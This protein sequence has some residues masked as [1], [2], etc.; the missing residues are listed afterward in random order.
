M[1]EIFHFSPDRDISAAENLLNFINRCRDELT[2]FGRDVKWDD[3]K[4][5]GVANFTKLGAHSMGC[6]ETDKL[7]RG[8][9]EFSKAYLRYQQGHAPT[10]TKNELKALRLVEAAL[11]QHGGA[12]DLSL[13]TPAVLDVAA[14]LA[15]ENYSPGASYH[16]GRELERLAKFVTKKHLIANDLSSWVSP[17]RRPNDGDGINKTERDRRQEKLPSECAL[18]AL[19]E[20]F[21]GNPSN[22]RDI[23]TSS[24]F[25][26]SMAAP[27]RITEILELP[28][29][30][31]YKEKDAHGNNTFGLRFYSGKGFGANVKAIPLT[32]AEVAQSAIARIQKLTA[33]ARKLAAWLDVGGDRFYRHPAC[34]NVG[35]NELL[36]MRQVCLALGLACHSAKACRLSMST[37]GLKIE[38]HHY[39][40]SSLWSIVREKQPKDFPWLSKEKGVRYKD[41]LFCM[42]KYQLGGVLNPSPVILWK[43]DVNVFN[44]DL[45]SSCSS[46]KKTKGI[47]ERFGY[48]QSDGSKIKLTSHQAR[49]LLN[50][51]AQRGGMTNYEISRWSGRADPRQNRTYNHMTDAEHVENVAACDQGLSLFGP[52]GEI[53]LNQPVSHTEYLQTVRRPG[54]VTSYGICD[55][56]FLMTPCQRFRDCINCSEHIFVKESGESLCNLKIR[57][58][59]VREQLL[60][61]EAGIARGEFGADRWYE[62]HKK[63]HDRLNQLLTLLESPD[64]EEG[65]RL[66]LHT[67][68]SF[69]VISR[70][71]NAVSSQSSMYLATGVKSVQDA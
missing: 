30:C 60:V 31:L 57:Q 22:P 24:T 48:K 40:L 68:S 36:T 25:A 54:H 70:A 59:E 20:I 5:P 11:L 63:T 53:A 62:Y 8:V 13:L 64:L 49:H 69:S 43:P 3:W 37:F 2:V 34:P 39:S 32:M 42:A 9:M 38:E 41:A 44:Y 19:A 35:E 10:K 7:N 18:D 71:I 4:W 1:A 14:Q 51:I 47:F 26:L 66:R 23:F 61:A 21:S 46:T 45:S 50:T 17:I 6:V 33:D 29:D 55:H 27:S 65:A 15:R 28:V 58:A 16:A 52:G 56:D 67:A 12:G